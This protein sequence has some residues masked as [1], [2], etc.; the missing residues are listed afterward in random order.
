VVLVGIKAANSSDAHVGL[1]LFQVADLASET[2]LVLVD[3]KTTNGASTK[4]AIIVWVRAV[5]A[6]LKSAFTISSGVTTMG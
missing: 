2:Q 5:A 3:M 1:Q 6:Q 4:V